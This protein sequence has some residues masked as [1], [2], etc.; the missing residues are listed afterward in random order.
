MDRSRNNSGVMPARPAP[1][2]HQHRDNNNNNRRPPHSFPPRQKNQPP[3]RYHPHNNSQ[4]NHNNNNNPQ[5]HSNHINSQ[6]HSQPPFHN[7]PHPNQQ[8]QQQRG[9]GGQPRLRQGP[10]PKHRGSVTKRG[11]NNRN[12]FSS[13]NNN[14]NIPFHSGTPPSLELTLRDRGCYDDNNEPRRRAAL[15]TLERILY[16][17]SMEVMMRDNN[18]NNKDNNNNNK[19]PPSN[20]WN[21]PRVALVCFGSYRLG[22]HKQSS[23]IDVLALSPPHCTRADFFVP[24]VDR[25]GHDPQVT[26]LHP[27]PSAYTPVI[28]FVLQGVQIDLLFARL[29]D[30]TKLVRFQQSQPSMLL[31]NN[32]QN[33]NN[34]M[35]TE[36]S[37]NNNRKSDDP[38]VSSRVEYLIDDSDLVGL[39]EAGVRSINGSRVSQFMLSLVPNV[40]TFRLV[41][42]AVKGWSDIHGV[43]SNVLGFLGGINW[44]ILVARVAIDNPL[45][46]PPR[47]LLIFF[48]T[49]SQWQ[50]PKPVT[51]GPICTEPPPGVTP[52]AAWNP[53]VNPRDGL[54]LMPIITPVFPSMNSAYNIGIPQLRRIQDEMC[55]AAYTLEHTRHPGDCSGIFQDGGFFNRH[56]NYLQIKIRAPNAEDFLHWFRLCESRMRLLIAS[57]ETPEV[58][59]WPFAKFFDRRFGNHHES[60]FFIAIRFA[61]AVET[62]DLR[63]LTSEFLHKINSWEGRKEGMDLSIDRVAHRHLPPFVTGATKANANS[64]H[65][66]SNNNHNIHN[67]NNRNNNRPSAVDVAMCPQMGASSQ[68]GVPAGGGMGQS[69]PKRAR[70]VL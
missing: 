40:E 20:P 42:R 35:A 23:D 50:W 31:R 52:M 3:Q 47:L 60:F 22:V 10:Q 33:M 6:G 51:L 46:D 8:Q 26:E 13:H 16:Q 14:N 63:Y 54:H 56:H 43:Q 53:K 21:V 69:P 55:R 17:W 27:I 32:S 65:P 37:N 4:N 5:R 30:A 38:P 9:G 2:E 15:E 24:L 12:S 25:L 41:L 34:P 68:M 36:V 7:H 67:N 61:P 28:K 57:L 29:Q 66:R 62:V 48:Q 39:D 70:T 64:N 1:S 11:N 49:Y 18:N 58:Q 44:A 45:A 19:T 59:A